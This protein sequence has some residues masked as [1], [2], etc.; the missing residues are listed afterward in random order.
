MKRKLF[1]AMIFFLMG[2]IAPAQEDK[3][4]IS[5]K[6]SSYLNLSLLMGIIGNI[7]SKNFSNTNQVGLSYSIDISLSPKDNENVGFFINF[8]SSFQPRRYYDPYNAVV[9]LTNNINY[10]QFALGPRIY[11]NSRNSFLDAGI[12]Y[13]NINKDE[14]VGATLGLGGKITISDMYAVSLA[15]RFNAA[16]VFNK[17]QLYY[18]LTAGIELNNKANI[19]RQP[20]DQK[21]SIAAFAGTYAADNYY[22]TGSVENAFSAELTYD[23]GKQTALLLN[24]I[25]KNSE[26]GYFN[27]SGQY[28]VHSKNRQNEITGGVRLYTKGQNI[29]LFAEGMTGL[30]L[31]TYEYLNHPYSYPHGPVTTSFYGITFG[32][33][34]EFTIIDNLLGSVKTDVSNYIQESSYISF[35]GGLKFKL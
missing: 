25:N 26:L 5:D 6:K 11:S 3:V 9:S 17:S 10:S 23:I 18:T 15:G 1:C 27:N 8:G 22:Y 35:F 16:D 20:K 29:R 34:V 7:S 28:V 32:G 12:G 13:F 31:I 14:V 2:N 24:Y 33:G 19:S 21:F 4:S 30:Y